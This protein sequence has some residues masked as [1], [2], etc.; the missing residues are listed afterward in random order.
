[1]NTVK[2]TQLS[3]RLVHSKALRSAE[4]PKHRNSCEA[5]GGVKYLTEMNTLLQ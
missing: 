4:R 1:M 3:L 2:F 5:R